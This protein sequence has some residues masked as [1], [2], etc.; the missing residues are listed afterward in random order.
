MFGGGNSNPTAATNG[1]PGTVNLGGGGGAGGS[2]CGAGAGAGGGGSGT[3]VFRFPGPS[4][5]RIS[6]SPCTNTKASCVGPA[7]DVVA[8]FTVSGTLTISY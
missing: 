2:N 4:G 7:N 8:T 6:V 3:A 1:Q 5:P